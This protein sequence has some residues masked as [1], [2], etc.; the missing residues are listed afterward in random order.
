[1]RFLPLVL[2]LALAGCGG[3]ARMY[4]A[5]AP[6]GALSCALDQATALGYSPTEGGTAGGFVRV[7]RKLNQTAGSVAS[8]AATRYMTL[9]FKGHNRTEYD[10]LTFTQAGANL[11]ISASGVKESGD[12]TSPT[13]SGRA[14]AEEI[15]MACSSGS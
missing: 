1:M 4:S 5:P 15:L 8:E 11:R 2:A 12:A 13:D 10:R 6:E 14:H 3:S 7:E 9:G